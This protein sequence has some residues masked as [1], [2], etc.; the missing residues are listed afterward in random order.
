MVFMPPR[1]LKSE[2]VTIR[3]PVYRLARLTSLRV[4]IGAYNQTLASRFSRKA[5]RIAEQCFD[6][7]TDRKAA[8]DWETPSGGGMRA[9]GVGAGITGV[10][11]DLILIDDPV[12][13]REEAES[14]VYR[15]KVWQWYTDDLYTRLEPG[16]ALVLVMTRWNEDDLAGRILKS[17]MAADWE[18]V[19]LP[20]IAEE[21]DALGR[22][23]GTPL[24]KDRYDLKALE[25]IRRTQGE[26][27]FQA[28]YQQRPS[29]RE[30]V[31]FK[32]G[33]LIIVDAAPAGLPTIR[34]WDEAATEGD[35]DY[36]AGVRM[37]G[38]DADGIFYVTDVVRGQWSTDA[39]DALIQ[40][41]AQLDGR[42]VRIRGAQEPGSAGVDRAKA[43][44]RMLAGFTVTTERASGPKEVRADP[45]SA[46]VNAGNVR[47]VRG[48]WNRTYIEELRTFPLGKHDDQVDAASDAFNALTARRIGRGA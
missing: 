45:Y 31:F 19:S 36:T 4:I 17:E 14:E 35:G 47:L 8:Y 43:F 1:S 12:K 40:Q 22:A 41:T 7:A 25:D 27:S 20:A 13:N 10:G 29:A 42:T 3:Y 23:P 15:E 18:V 21:D 16:G 37:C 2:T 39:R 24:C 11:G 32:V 30:G 48:D 28:L 6:L 26:Y 38:P 46:Q 34:A 9:V 33:K 5:R 44:I